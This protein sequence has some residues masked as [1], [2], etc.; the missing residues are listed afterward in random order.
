[1]FQ[2]EPAPVLKCQIQ[3]LINIIAVRSF[4]VREQYWKHDL[5][6]FIFIRHRNPMG[7]NQLSPI[8][9]FFLRRPV[10][11][12]NHMPQTFRQ[13][14]RTDGTLS[15]Q[16]HELFILKIKALSAPHINL[17]RISGFR[18]FLLHFTGNPLDFFQDFRLLPRQFFH[19]TSFDNTPPRLLPLPHNIRLR[20][21]SAPARSDF[22]PPVPRCGFPPVACPLGI[23]H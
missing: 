2:P 15:C 17:L 11:I 13:L 23:S 5:Y 18:Q 9:L 12:K 20:R 21:E 7:L 3:W 4:P 10:A 19:L 16:F 8:S 1:M 6:N 14:L 22:H